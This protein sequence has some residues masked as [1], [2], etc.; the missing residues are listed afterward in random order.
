MVSIFLAYLLNHE[1][2]HV[3]GS[4]ERF[5]DFIYIDDVVDAWLLALNNPVTFGKT[6]N[7]ATGKKTPVGTLVEEE[8]RSFGLDPRT[9]PI[10]YEGNTPADQFGLY[11]DISRIRKDLNWQ[12]QTT[13][14]KG[15]ENMV[16]WL[17]QTMDSQCRKQ[18]SDRS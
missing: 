7:L 4:K 9:Y 11:A 12:P 5:R 2:I 10:K 13:L 16:A 3:K 1:P 14:S 15:L 6:Y 17:R 8:I 18:G